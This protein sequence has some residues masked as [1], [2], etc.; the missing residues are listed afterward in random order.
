MQQAVISAILGLPPAETESAD[1]KN[2]T[3]EELQSANEQLTK[4][5]AQYAEY[6]KELEKE[7]A[8]ISK[9]LNPRQ[10]GKSLEGMRASLLRLL[11]NVTQKSK[12]KLMAKTLGIESHVSLFLSFR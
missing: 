10:P 5:S 6:V 12:V 3:A 8:Y 4:E 1:N 11:V 7:N 9:Y 2:M